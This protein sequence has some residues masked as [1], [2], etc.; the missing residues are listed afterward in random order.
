MDIVEAIKTRKSI[1]KFKPDPVPRNLLAEILETACRT[2]SAMNSQPWEFVVLGGDVLEKLK[3]A[4][5]EKLKA[6]EPPQSEHTV[7]GWERETV[8]FS[9]QVGLAKELFRLMDIGREDKDKRA[10]WTARGF[11]YFDAP[12]AIVILTD[13]SL[14]E[15]APLLDLGAIM[16]TICLA[17]LNHGLGT[18]IEDQ[19]VMYPKVLREVAAIPDNKRIVISIAIGYPESDFP[20]N[21]IETTREPLENIATWLGF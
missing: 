18:C 21:Q 2:P 4:N 12:A 15:I 9:R 3:Q 16:Q 6:G 7:V 11:R 14:A 17:A 10:E 13:T 19:G 1:R 5:I 20:A 8:Y